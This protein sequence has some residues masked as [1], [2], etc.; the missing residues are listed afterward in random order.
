[1][2]KKVQE[3]TAIVIYDINR[4][5]VLIVHRPKNATA[6]PDEWGF[7][8]TVREKKEESWEHL[9]HKA[10]KIKLGVEIEII[11]YM[12]EDIID[13]GNYILKLRDYE[14]RIVKGKPS[15]PQKDEYYTQ[16]DD[17]KYSSDFKPLIKSAKKG[18][19]CTKIFLE[20]KGYKINE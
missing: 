2:N 16:Y 11:R 15:V 5:K 6:L 14:C 12:G 18:S 8:A 9:A 19:L 4:K 7:P 1:M 10:A 3:A 13:R 20:E 17:M